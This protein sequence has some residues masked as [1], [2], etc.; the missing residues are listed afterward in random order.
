MLSL[1]ALVL[2]GA[3]LISPI[4]NYVPR[5]LMDVQFVDAE[6]LRDQC[7]A[8]EHLGCEWGYGTKMIHARL[9]KGSSE[10]EE[11]RVRH[12]NSHVSEYEA[13]GD[14]NRGHIGW[15]GSAVDQMERS[16]RHRQVRN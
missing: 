11:C 4:Y 6:T 7:G 1:F 10:F 2:C 15:G 16:V 14:P 13:T 9:L 3:T 5:Q 12:L 8:G